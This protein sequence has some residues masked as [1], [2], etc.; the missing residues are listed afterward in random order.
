MKKS[1]PAH[2]EH[3]ARRA[4]APRQRMALQPSG[5]AS[6]VIP[7]D[8]VGEEGG[9]VD[10]S[11][12]VSAVARALAVLNAFRIDD[13]VLGNSELT[14]RTGLSKPTVSRLTY[15][16]AR[17]G[18][19]TFNPRHR[20]YQLGPSVVALGNVAMGSM[21]VRQVARPL[22]R[23]LARQ[24][25]F[26]VGLGIRDRHVMI[27]SEACEGEGLVGLRLFAGSRIPILTTAMGRAYLSGLEATE[28]E[29]L[30]AEL[31]TKH[32]DEWS[33][34]MKSVRTAITDVE[35]RGFCMS[36]GD[37]QNDIHGVAAPIR[38]R[39]QVYAINLGGPAYL[40]PE[41]LLRDELG[42][43]VSEVARKIEEAISPAATPLPSYS[44]RG[45]D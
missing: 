18:Y 11:Q 36:V 12:F 5:Q 40:L 19:L 14:E 27:Y 24:A 10:D 42:P 33:R 22:M 41:A 45:D 32:G 39:G 2:Y 38:S 3:S 7:M 1:L 26:N 16:L 20:V 21:D 6:T 15:T 17:C 13:D 4:K 34:L 35:A 31:K 37:W 9:M 25:N 29:R 23:E 8:T 43:R 30:L 28:R 44:D